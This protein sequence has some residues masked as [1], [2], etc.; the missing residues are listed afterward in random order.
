MNSFK[1]WT[2]DHYSKTAR[3]KNTFMDSRNQ[4][5]FDQSQEFGS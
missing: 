3:E 4:S 2:S 1:N 5:A